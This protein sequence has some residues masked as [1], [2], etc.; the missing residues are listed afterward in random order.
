MVQF[1]LPDGKAGKN[2]LGYESN[3][4]FYWYHCSFICW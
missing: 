1:L 2:L 3:S 4:P